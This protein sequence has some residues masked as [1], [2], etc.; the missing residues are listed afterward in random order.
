MKKKR[1]ERM[2]PFAI[3][4]LFIPSI[5]FAKD[6]VNTNNASQI[7]T[8]NRNQSRTTESKVSTH[9]SNGIKVQSARDFSWGTSKNLLDNHGDFSDMINTVSTSTT[10]V[11]VQLENDVKISG[12][13]EWS[14]EAGK[15]VYLDLA[16]HKLHAVQGNGVDFIQVKGELFVEDSSQE[17][18][19]S[20]SVENAQK[21]IYVPEGGKFTLNSGILTRTGTYS[22]SDLVHIYCG[23]M[24]MNGGILNGGENIGY[25]AVYVNGVKD[26]E[27]GKFIMNNGKITGNISSQS[28]VGAGIYMVTNATF[29]MNG[30]S[31]ENNIAKGSGGAIST[32]SPDD[33]EMLNIE[34]HGGTIKNNY[35][36]KSGGAIYLSNGSLILDESKSK[37]EITGNTAKNYG[38]AIAGGSSTSQQQIILMEGGT[39]EGNSANLTGSPGAGAIYYRGIFTMTGGKITKNKSGQ[40]AVYMRMN[41]VLNMIGGSITENVGTG[42]QEGAGIWTMGKDTINI[43]ANANITGNYMETPVANQTECNIYLSSSYFSGLNIL[44][45]GDEVITGLDE[46]IKVSSDWTGKVGVHGGKKIATDLYQISLNGTE[47]DI[48]KVIPDSSDFITI[49]KDEKLYLYKHASHKWSTQVDANK[50]SMS[51]S[52]EYCDFH[53]PLTLTLNAKDM[54]YSGNKYDGATLTNTITE[55]TGIKPGD[56]IYKGRGNTTHSSTTTAPVDAGTYTASVTI[57]GKTASADFEITKKEINPTLTLKDWIYGESASGVNLSGNDGNGKVTYA[58]KKKDAEDSTYKNITEAELQNLSTGGYTL[59]ATIAETT[60]YKAAS[61][62]CNFAV[63]KQPIKNASVTMKG[64]TYGSYK[65]TENMPVLEDGSN[66]GNGAVTY[67]YYTDKDCTKETTAENGASDNGKVPM[68]AGTYYVKAIIAETDNY[69]SAE[70]TTSFTIAKKKITATVTSVEKV[71]DGTKNAEL[72][73]TVET[74]IAGET[75]KISGLEGA[76]ADKNAG[77]DK[78]IEISTNAVTIMAGKGTKASDY[79]IE[80]PQSVKGTITAKPIT[81]DI[82]ANDSIYGNV[83]E[84]DASLSG[85]IEEDKVSVT[86]KYSGTANDGTEVKDSVEVPEKA[87]SYTVIVVINDKNYSLPETSESFTIK[88]AEVAVPDISSKK[89]NGE[90]QK[91]DIEESSLYT[92]ENQGGKNVG[93]YDVILSLKDKDNYIWKDKSTSED[94]TLKFMITKASQEAPKVTTVSETI[95]GQAN[96][97]ITGVTSAM[98]YRKEGDSKYTS[99]S[100]N[101]ITG[102][103]AGT[104]FVRYKEDENHTASEETKVTVAEGRQLKITVPTE[105]TGYELTIDKDTSDWHGEVK[106]TFKL[107]DGYSKTNEFAV[108][109]N[110]EK[111]TLD[112]QNTYTISNL[113][114]DTNI[115]VIGV[116]DT[117]APTGTITV[118][119]KNWESFEKDVTFDI[120][121]K[122]K[123][124]V[125][126]T[127][128][129]SGSGVKNISYY[130]ADKAMTKEE[131]EALSE[132]SWTAYDSDKGIDLIENG[133]YVIYAK[134]T[135]NAG[136]TSYISS[137]GMVMD[138]SAP[139][140]KGIESGNT[141][142][143]S[144]EITVTDENLATVT[145]DGE[146]VTLDENGK[147]ILVPK[148]GAYTIVVT[149][150]AGNKTTI[151]NV[152][153]NKEVPS[154]TDPSASGESLTYNGTE[155]TLI[156]AGQTTGGKLE[157]SLD[158][159]NWSSELPTAKNAGTYDVR[160]RVVGDTDYQDVEEKT[161]TVTIAP[162][163]IGITWGNTQFTYNG[164][165]QQ[166]TATANGVLEGENCEITVK[167][168]QKAVGKYIATATE[169]S[170]QNYAL[171]ETGITTEFEIKAQKKPQ[172]N[173]NSG[174]NTISEANAK[175]NKNTL[176]LNL[177]LKVSQAGNKINISWGKV[178]GAKGYDVYVQYCGKTFNAKS[179]NQVK[180]GNKTKIT[181]K[182]VNGKK[183]NLKKNYKIYV[184]AYTYQGKKKVNLAK[185]IAA[186]I[187]GRK[188]TKETNV[189]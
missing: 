125:K 104:Y 88:K 180:S 57:N 84:A 21:V 72:K 67:I 143:K 77:T 174:N 6:T 108:M 69:M 132:E 13:Q 74:G 134:V 96:G 128:Q 101:E 35:A 20:I 121:Y 80:Y 158:G 110:G 28:N 90:N 8:S 94:L 159:E 54:P 107:K 183:L 117:T 4:L 111:V 171:P 26:G 3:A 155:Q 76:F 122:E 56:I 103:P 75:L 116:A 91:A 9:E 188:N 189:K 44:K 45:E 120:F 157:Y 34:I 18:T 40:A 173:N 123:Q 25:G 172:N 187:V 92:V 127:A 185:S 33:T 141:Y 2:L 24:T 126:I 29:I 49:L 118:G 42:N 30:G 93:T 169:I 177:G 181:V 151:D 161:L 53:T 43:G 160:Y 163:V 31:I 79:E 165:T 68:N 16:G 32:Y 15:K 85:V 184:V 186:H 138:T 60:N 154:V 95:K 58:Y 11:Y 14:I 46:D 182:K 47:E 50:V 7:E 78:T 52:G 178:Q 82:T 113:E 71:Y 81:V 131:V 66:P 164:K 162:K 12:I 89:Y 129:D 139:V 145:V 119:E 146:E 59:R 176:A 105:Q 17:Q 150:K 156:T 83:K 22:T 63:T 166:P 55:A 106:L 5:V 168:G 153:V 147:Y 124:N 114:K 142:T 102:L 149:D 38:G 51:C 10:P 1:L 65:E 148:D 87:G 152:T 115:T 100:G 137:N 19:G 133:K 36:G 97:K 62:T 41:S 99:V 98:E 64:W 136:N 70:A 135:D 27:G 39:I 144:T 61:A 109:V 86:L 48:A 170:N 175:R 167:G 179:L 23:T 73:A 37:L 112:D 140:I 130:V